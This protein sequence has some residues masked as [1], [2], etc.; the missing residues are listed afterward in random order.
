LNERLLDASLDSNRGILDAYDDRVSILELCVTLCRFSE[1]RLLGCAG[2]SAEDQAKLFEPYSFVTSGWVLKAG[3]SGLGLSMAK[4]FVERAGGSIGVESKEG[5]GSTFFFSIPFPLV[6]VDLS[7]EREQLK[8]DVGGAVLQKSEV[9]QSTS[10]SGVTVVHE[11]ITLT[12]RRASMKEGPKPLAKVKSVE[13][14]DAKSDNSDVSKG[15][16]DGYMKKVTD[17]QDNRAVGCQR[18]VLLVEDT[19]INRVSG[20]RCLRFG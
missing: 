2:I 7:N 6:P 3:V 14:P 12:R 17:K 20:L 9:T 10:S 4:R 5:S 15:R 13:V 16:A 18:K 1:V 11:S 19:R 8:S